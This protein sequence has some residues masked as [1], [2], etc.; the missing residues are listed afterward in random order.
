MI[1]VALKD[2]NYNLTFKTSAWNENI[3]IFSL[4]TFLSGIIPLQ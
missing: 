1:W 3:R 4:K 2:P